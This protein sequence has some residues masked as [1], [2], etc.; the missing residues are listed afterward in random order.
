MDNQ[1]F[2]T[3][4]ISKATKARLDNMKSHRRET[5]EEVIVK[6]I[7]ILN[8]FKSNPSEGLRKLKNIEEQ[9]RILRS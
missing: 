8:S 7:E 5:Y 4:K 9:R 6:N 1:E 3:I 2:T